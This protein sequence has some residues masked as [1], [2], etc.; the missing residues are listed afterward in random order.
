MEQLAKTF[1]CARS[2]ILQSS[3]PDI[4]RLLFVPL[5]RRIALDVD[6]CGYAPHLSRRV[7]SSKRGTTTSYYPIARPNVCAV[8]LLLANWNQIV[9]DIKAFAEITEACRDLV[10]FPL[11]RL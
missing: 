5:S 8:D 3:H 1:G 4:H 6:L 9:L 11:A 2:S 7:C 10:G